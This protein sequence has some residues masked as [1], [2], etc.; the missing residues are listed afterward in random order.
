MTKS[1][2][3]QAAGSWSPDA[4]CAVAG[5]NCDTFQDSATFKHPYCLD[6]ASSSDWIFGLWPGPPQRF[7]PTGTVT[8]YGHTAFQHVQ[9]DS[10]PAW[11]SI[12]NDLYIGDASGAPGGS[13]AYCN[14]GHTYRGTDGEI[15]GGY[16]ILGRRTLR[17]GTRAKNARTAAFRVPISVF[18]RHISGLFGG[19]AGLRSRDLGASYS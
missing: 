5:N 17:C 2:V 1:D 13:H 18:R 14:Q 9:A 15:C 12:G 8:R 10:W 3:V 11:G 7:E 19:P 4:C 6:S 16:N